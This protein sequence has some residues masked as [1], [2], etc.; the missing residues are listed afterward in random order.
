M[1]HRPTTFLLALPVLL[2][3]A[4]CSRDA[5]ESTEQLD[6]TAASGATGAPAPAPPPTAPHSVPQTEALTLRQSREAGKG[7]SAAP[8]ISVVRPV[9]GVNAGTAA[10]MLIRTGNASV[11]VRDLAR[12]IAAVRNLATQLGGYVA[13][14][15]VVDGR[16]QVKSATLELKIPAAQFDRVVNGLE[17]LGRVESVTVDAQDVGEE[18]V[19]VAARVANAK[20]LEERLVALLA[21]RTG[22]LEDVLAVERELARVREEIER[23]AGRLRYLESRTAMSTITIAIHEP[24]PVLG[25]TNDPIAE[26]FRDAW[27]NA[28][29][30]VAWMIA[31]MG[32]L[33]PAA[34]IGGGMYLL[35]R[36]VWRARVA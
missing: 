13:N 8:D 24:F 9:A 15:A 23:Y 6:Y 32:V 14:T 11:E 34:V 35:G 21:T 2:L 20:R 17:P 1:R 29:G 4:A 22:R 7:R 33:V 25:R 26:A 28:V 3:A 36:R 27:R 18:Y 30:F 12:G 19:D 16:D 31:A 10:A 5:A